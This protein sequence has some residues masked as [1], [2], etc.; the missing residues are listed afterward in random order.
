MSSI[1]LSFQMT[2]TLHYFP[3]RGRGEVIRLALSAKNE[4]YNEELVNFQNMK[5]DQEAYPFG[6]CPR[7]T[8]GEFDLVQS[9]TI[10]R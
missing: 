7:F 3:L 5:D 8:D 9:N 4:P 1:G 6:Q 2:F 10:L